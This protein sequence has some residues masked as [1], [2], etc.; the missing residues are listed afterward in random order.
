M[1]RRC[2]HEPETGYRYSKFD[3]AQ[4]LLEGALEL[5]RLNLSLF[6]ACDR[7]NPGSLCAELS[8]WSDARRLAQEMIEDQSYPWIRGVDRLG[9]T[10]VHATCVSSAAP[11]ITERLHRGRAARNAPLR[12]GP[13][14]GSLAV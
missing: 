9:R 7:L 11:W 13:G 14:V 3:H 8:G 1:S 5:Q 4:H 12:R 2:A 10:V 6:P